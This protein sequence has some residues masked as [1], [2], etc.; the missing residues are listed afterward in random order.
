VIVF[1]WC[2]V[3]A[4]GAH[5][6]ISS[7]SGTNVLFLI[8]SGCVAGGS[9]ICYYKALSIGDVGRVTAIDKSSVILTM[10]LGISLLGE[11]IN[12]LKLIGLSAIAVGTY[13]MLGK[14][15]R[16]GTANAYMF[17][18]AASAVLAAMT[19]VF[20]K[21]GLADIDANLG[22]AI[23]TIIVLIFSGL[24]LPV[25]GSTKR[26]D[27]V[28]RRDMVFLCL[29][30]IATSLAWLCY[31]NAIQI[32]EVS[33]VAPIDRLSTVITIAFSAAI[34]KE[35]ITKPMWVGVGIQTVGTIILTL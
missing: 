27:T 21:I 30:A 10:L 20:A 16:G 4:I 6:G 22:T 35:R 15:S 14:L 11:N 9:W 17:F 31:F 13:F 19:A 8:L 3:F 32:G 23:R 34:L 5:R 2:F 7:L 28:N 24:M 25:T 18:A 29:S 1:L 26:F 12:T 33:I